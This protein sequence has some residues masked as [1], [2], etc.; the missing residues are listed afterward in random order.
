MLND[1]G[2]LTIGLGCDSIEFEISPYILATSR[3]FSDRRALRTM[4]WDRIDEED[5]N[6]GDQKPHSRLSGTFASS[7][8]KVPS[9]QGSHGR[10]ESL[11]PFEMRLVL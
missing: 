6:L 2:V 7:R 9:L 4:R 10:V 1:R 5:L 3:G 8:L 11:G